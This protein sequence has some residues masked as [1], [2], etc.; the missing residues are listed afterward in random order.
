MDAETQALNKARELLGEHFENFVIVTENEGEHGAEVTFRCG[1]SLH[2]AIGLC[3][4]AHHE[5]LNSGE[6]FRQEGD[7]I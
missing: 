2:A 5:L 3:S 6:L 4:R 1:G 7:E